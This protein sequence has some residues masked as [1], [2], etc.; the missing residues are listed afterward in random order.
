MTPEDLLQKSCIKWFRLQY[1]A[2][3]KMLLAVPNGGKRNVREAAKLKSMG[4]TAGVSDL[5]LLVQR[6]GYGSL[7][8]ELKNGK[9]GRQSQAQHEWE[10]NAI[11]YV[12]K[13]VIW[14]SVDEFMKEVNEYLNQ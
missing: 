3:S 6:H 8:I 7:C 9:K 10:L 12:N 14:R 5:I 1:A 4:V 2:L 11:T 13:Y